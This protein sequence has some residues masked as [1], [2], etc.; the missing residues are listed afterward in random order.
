MDENKAIRDKN[1][2][3]AT[4]MVLLIRKIISY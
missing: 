3:L 1:S 2:V 4:M